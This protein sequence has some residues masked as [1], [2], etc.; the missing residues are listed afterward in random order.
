VGS[1]PWL[2]LTM[3][4]FLTYSCTFF[5]T[6]FSFSRLPH[7]GLASVTAS[8]TFMIRR[9][10]L[11]HRAAALVDVSHDESMQELKESDYLSDRKIMLNLGLL[12]GG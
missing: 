2:V 4:F 8:S 7:M 12:M 5:L 11:Q 6:S 10:G 3:P 9:R 1:Q